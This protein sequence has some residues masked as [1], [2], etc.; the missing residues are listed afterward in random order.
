M[1]AVV[2]G[3]SPHGDQ[4]RCMV[5]KCGATEVVHYCAS[6]KHLTAVQ[7]TSPPPHPMEPPPT[8]TSNDGSTSNGI[9]SHGS[10]SSDPPQTDLSLCILVAV[11]VHT[12]FQKGR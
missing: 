2:Q 12:V 6:V 5:Y 3:P 9:T 11:A 1:L 7:A 4:Y 8:M 10:T